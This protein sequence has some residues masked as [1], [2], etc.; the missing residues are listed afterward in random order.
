VKIK[1]IAI[2]ICEAC[3]EGRGE[4]CHT[5]GCA[6]FLHTGDLPIDPGV[7]EVLEEFEAVV[8]GETFVLDDGVGTAVTFHFDVTGTYTPPGGYDATNIRVDISGDVTA[9]HVAATAKTAINGATTLDITA[10]T[11]ETGGLLRLENDRPGIDGNH[12]IRFTGNNTRNA[13]ITLDN[14]L[15]L[16]E[17]LNK[18]FKQDQAAALEVIKDRQDRAAASPPSPPEPPPIEQIEKRVDEKFRVQA[19]RPDEIL[20]CSEEI[21]KMFVSEKLNEMFKQDQAAALEVI[22]DSET[23]RMGS[24][25]DVLKRTNRA[26]MELRELLNYIIS[27]TS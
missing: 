18:K 12:S 20:A 16:L 1:K 27:Q 9:D 24:A 17:K 19:M 4:E 2:Q 13:A 5:P 21:D 11:V 14:M 10:G 25:S 8:D 23:K 6:L 26:L 7:Y 15:V 22:K 3:L